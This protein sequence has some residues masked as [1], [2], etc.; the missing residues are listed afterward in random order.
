M[1][2]ASFFSSLGRKKNFGS[3]STI[4]GK[5]FQI[6]SAFGQVFQFSGTPCVICGFLASLF[7]IHHSFGDHA[8][9]FFHF[10][11]FLSFSHLGGLFYLF[12][13][14][15][16][17]FFLPGQFILLSLGFLGVSASEVTYVIVDMPGYVG[18][19]MVEGH[20]T[21]VC[22][23]KQQARHENMRGI[24]RTQLPLV[25]CCGMTVHK[26]QGLALADGCV[27]NMD[28]EPTWCPLNCIGLAFVGMSRTK[29]FAQ[30]AFKYVPDYWVFFSVKDT[31][32]F[33]WRANLELRLDELHD[34]TAASML[35]RDISVAEDLGRHVAWSEQ[36]RGAALTDAEVA[37]LKH[38]LSVRGML[39]DPHYPDRPKRGPASK[40][41]GGRSKRG[42]MRAPRAQGQAVDAADS[43]GPPICAAEEEYD[44]QLQ[45]EWERM[46][47]VERASREEAEA[48]QYGRMVGEEVDDAAAGWEALRDMDGYGYDHDYIVRQQRTRAC[49]I[50]LPI[51]FAGARQCGPQL[52]RMSNH[53][54]ACACQCGPHLHRMLSHAC[55]ALSESLRAA[56]A[57]FVQAW[58]VASVCSWF[59][60]QWLVG[61]CCGHRVQTLDPTKEIK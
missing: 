58:A 14:F 52:H 44:R 34:A 1:L 49:R 27:F 17:S 24:S 5:L 9:H 25:L 46:Q 11:I 26:G 22:I 43:S 42:I 47:A 38:M 41:G 28:H 56:S 30:M 60:L 31:D 20:P 55:V 45:V 48:E 23:P 29:D 51:A 19:T 21:W 13:P 8:Q 3:Q 61:S 40:A 7:H 6:V 18:P 15:C 54:F 16:I 33:K 39:D 35:G 32:I 12:V 53:A 2:L 10:A 4:W 36:R 50:P 59:L 37:D 57:S